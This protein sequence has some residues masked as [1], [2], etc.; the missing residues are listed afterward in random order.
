L[1]L[2]YPFE[3]LLPALAAKRVQATQLEQQK[4]APHRILEMLQEI[5]PVQH[6][7]Q[8]PD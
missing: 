4:K 1:A 6:R 5:P 7:S 3:A 8:R 2:K